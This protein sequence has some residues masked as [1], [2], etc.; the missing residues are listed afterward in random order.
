MGWGAF[1]ELFAK[2]FDVLSWP[3]FTLVFPLFASVRA[4]ETDSESKNQQ[5]LSFWVLFALVKILESA[6]ANLLKWFPFWPYTK[7][8]ITVLLVIPC[9]SG[10]FYVYRQFIR[11]HISESPLVW[12][13][14]IF[15]V[16]SIP[17]GENLIA[18]EK[19]DLVNVVAKNI[20]EVEDEPERHILYQGNSECA[21]ETT[22]REFICPVSAKNIQKE[23]CCA[24]CL[25][26]TTSKTCLSIHVKGTKHR[27]KVEELKAYKK[28]KKNGYKSSLVTKRPN[29]IILLNQFACSLRSIRFCR[30]R[31]PDPGWKKLNT[32][33]SLDRENASF[34]GL[35][36]D[37]EGE[38]LCAFVS[39]APR[40][41][42]FSIELGAI[43]RGLVL[44]LGLGIKY[45]WVESDSMSAVKTINNEQS[46]NQKADTCLNKIWEL[47]KN[48]DDYEITHSWRETNRAA[49]Y[50]AKMVILGN[51]V[52]LSP[53]NFPPTLRSIIKADA[54]G[55]IYL[56]GTS[57]S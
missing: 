25:V 18:S 47:L 51:D 20:F 17:R 40:D 4:I 22:L 26:S 45:I 42:I 23:W 43:W 13:W 30:W 15:S 52:V 16:D 11:S 21:Y 48:F 24:L 28:A 34:G 2:L 36:R 5:C 19:E 3:S 50:L 31:K 6:L 9:F 56:R 41:D 57:N 33:G 53:V 8:V 39:K 32:D 37:F 44:A 12:K 49:D 54:Q 46:Y 29:G 27:A 14:N 38:P 7:G 55:T 10:A 35:L 1:L